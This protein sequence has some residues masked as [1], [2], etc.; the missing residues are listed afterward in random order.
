MKKCVAVA[1][2]KKLSVAFQERPLLHLPSRR[3]W[4]KF[5]RPA[6]TEGAHEN[7]QW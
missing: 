3:L 4:E 7:S 1:V 2:M 5:L 6:E